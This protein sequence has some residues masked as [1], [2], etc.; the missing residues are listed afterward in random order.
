LHHDVSSK[1]AIS[2]SVCFDKREGIDYVSQLSWALSSSLATGTKSTG[3]D[4]QSISSGFHSL[5]DEA[6]AISPGVTAMN[7]DQTVQYT[8]LRVLR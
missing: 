5:L 1:E 6:I 7:R 3:L 4:A 8:K 2:N